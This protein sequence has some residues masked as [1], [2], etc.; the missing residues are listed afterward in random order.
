LNKELDQIGG[1]EGGL[2]W[3]SSDLLHGYTEILYQ[4]HM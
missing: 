1:G 4:L 2:S 3:L